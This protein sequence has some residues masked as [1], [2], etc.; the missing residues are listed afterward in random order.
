M[1]AGPHDR[2]GGEGGHVDAVAAV[3]AGAL[4]EDTVA[5]LTDVAVELTGGWFGIVRPL[6]KR[7]VAVDSNLGEAYAPMSRPG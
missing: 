6:V 2:E 4:R 7:V 3:A 1:T 5:S